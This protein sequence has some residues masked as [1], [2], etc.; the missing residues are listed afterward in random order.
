MKVGQ[1]YVGEDGQWYYYTQ[2]DLDKA[3]AYEIGGGWAYYGRRT[4]RDLFKDD[5]ELRKEYLRGYNEKPYGLK[6]YG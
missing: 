4:N 2:R 5:P 3:K 6:D 1:A